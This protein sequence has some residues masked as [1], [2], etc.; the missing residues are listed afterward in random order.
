[1]DIIT[2]FAVLL[3]ICY[4]IIIFLAIFYRNS[5]RPYILAIKNRR[6]RDFGNCL[7][8]IRAFIPGIIVKGIEI[9]ELLFID[10]LGRPILIDNFI[11]GLVELSTDLKDGVYAKYANKIIKNYT[12]YNLGLVEVFFMIASIG[13]IFDG[14]MSIGYYVTSAIAWYI[15]NFSSDF[16]LALPAETRLELATNY[17]YF[18]KIVLNI[19]SC[20]ELLWNIR[21]TLY[22]L[23]DINIRKGWLRYIF[24]PVWQVQRVIQPFMPS[25]FRFPTDV[26]VTI[27]VLDE[28]Q[29]LIASLD[30]AAFLNVDWEDVMHNTSKWF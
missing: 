6:L 10:N 4:S 11:L 5:L 1:M 3:L 19:L 25:I 2:F 14:I 28:L 13:S 24:D 18:Q 7:Y 20:Y 8:F 15:A 30:I 12:A 16:L 23:P 29:R 17:L 27:T 21:A 22:I 9:F 26:P